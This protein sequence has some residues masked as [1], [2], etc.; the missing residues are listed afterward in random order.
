M[1]HIYSNLVD[2]SKLV[3]QSPFLAI[4]AKTRSFF[5]DWRRFAPPTADCNLAISCDGHSKS[6]RKNSIVGTSGHDVS[7]SG[8]MARI[9]RYFAQ[10]AR[11]GGHGI[12]LEQLS[13]NSGNYRNEVSPERA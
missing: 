1:R 9:E 7:V 13:A 11:N 4:L 5:A 6:S 12:R 3:R 8:G 10:L 2:S